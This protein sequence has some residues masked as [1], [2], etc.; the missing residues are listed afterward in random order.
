MTFKELLERGTETKTQGFADL[1]F[2]KIDPEAQ[3]NYERDF[4]K[5]SEFKM[6]TD[7]PWA[8]DVDKAKIY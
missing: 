8:K 5:K 3:S 1:R 4:C 6:Y 7:E 2:T